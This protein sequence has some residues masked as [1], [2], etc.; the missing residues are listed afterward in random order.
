MVFSMV[1]N[2]KAAFLLRL[3]VAV[4]S[5]LISSL[6][7]PRENISPL[8]FAS[9]VLLLLALENQKALAAG[10]IGFVGGLAFY[11]SQIEWLSLYLGPIPWLALG[12]LEAAIF[13]VGCIFI[14]R[15]WT[16]LNSQSRASKQFRVL[17]FGFIIATI[18]TAREWVS[19]TLPYGGFP[20]SRLAQTQSETFLA[21]W[22]FFGGIGSLSF[23]IAWISAMV[24]VW[25]SVSTKRGVHFDIPAAIAAVSL[26]AIPACIDIPVNN[27]AGYLK[28]AAVQGNANAGLFANVDRGTFLKN[29]LD[30]SQPLLG[31]DFDLV[32][33]P[34]NASDLSPFSD[35][36][37]NA[38]ITSFVNDGI[39]APLIFGT[40]TERGDEIFN[41]SILWQPEVGPTDYYDKKRPVPFAEYVPDHDFWYSLAPD[42]VGLI[43]RGYTFGT[44]D[45]IFEIEN[46][47]VGVLICF[48]IAID[49]IGRDLVNEGASIILA[50]TNN[51]D[52]GHSDET[53]QQAAFAKLRAI[54]TGRV[55]VNDSTVGLSAIFMPDGS[56]L[57]QLPTFEAGVME[58]NLPLSNSKTPAS[59]IGRYFDL[60]INVF[61]ALIICIS[62]VRRKSVE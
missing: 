27:D 17:F 13:S 2:G 31:R 30:A 11:L 50:Q 39:K 62:F 15:V 1:P 56:T 14:A 23:V 3:L 44:R 6:A 37:A 57:Q 43:S 21:K 46:N 48:E 49:D 26:I 35:A 61:A 10:T 55:V 32:V 24:A 47:K 34:E 53:F 33:W 54:E 45:G 40:I 28:V 52:F 42:L 58:A 16:W 12:V 38:Q 19:I 41:S 8:I 18:W 9:L 59:F 29:H 36:I 20:W 60:G 51:A 25:L 4:M 5:G 22:V 7:F